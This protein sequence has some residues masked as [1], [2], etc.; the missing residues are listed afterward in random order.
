MRWCFQC[1]IEYADGVADCVE[2]GVQ[3]VDEAPVAAGE[4]GHDDEE[5]LAYELH[6]WAGESRRLLDQELTGRGIAHAWQGAALVVRAADEVAVDEVVEVI[7][8]SGGPVLDPAAD[9]VAYEVGDWAADEQT[10]F[11]ELLGRL[12]IAHEFD[13]LG[14]LVVLATDEDTVEEALDAFQGGADERP[15][16]GGLDANLVLTDLFVACDRLR[17]DPR[18]NRAV[19]N[20]VDGAPLVAGHRPPF[21]FDPQVW[22]SIGE[23]V[24]ELADLLAAGDTDHDELRE[25]ATQLAEGLRRLT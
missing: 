23:R 6:E 14:D 3:L 1:G 4:V 15:E 7:D 24:A 21:G 25:R 13:E 12:G 10:A 19:E 11:A 8:G 2:C 17:R 20:L 9:K 22:N 5:Q 16:F 18:D